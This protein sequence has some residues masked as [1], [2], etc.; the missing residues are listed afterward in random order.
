MIDYFAFGNVVIDDIVR[1]DGRAAL[2][3]LGGASVHALA[4]MRVWAGPPAPPRGS[5]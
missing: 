5:S 2:D 3:T 4:G 1:W